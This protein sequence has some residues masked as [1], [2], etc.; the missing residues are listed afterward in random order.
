MWRMLGRLLVGG[1]LL[2]FVA[3]PIAGAVM[4]VDSAPLVA[5]QRKPTPEDA[6]AVTAMVRRL[7]QVTQAPGGAGT[8]SVSLA[9]INA[10]LALGERLIP[11][12]RSEAVARVGAIEAR[13]S[14]P[15]GPFGW[16]N[17]EAVLA[18]YEV[19][20]R[21]ARLR[22]G[23]LPLPPRVTL[24]VARTVGDIVLG[25][26]TATMAMQAVSQ[27]AISPEEVSFRLEMD[28]AQ[29]QGLAFRLAGLLRGA[30]M[31]T[32]PEIDTYYTAL[33]TAID[34]G[35]LPDRGS[36]LP[37]VIWTVKRA[38]ERAAPGR[39][40]HELTAALFALTRVCGAQ[41]FRMVVG[42]LAG[43]PMQK[44]TRSWS[45]NCWQVRLAG[46]PDTRRHFITA[47]A[48][49]AASTMKVSFTIGE[50]KELYDVGW[51]GGRFDFTD[52]AANAS[53]IRFADRF[54]TAPLD[55]WPQL[56]ARVQAEDDILIG[57]EGIPGELPRAE[58][59]ARFVAVDSPAYR[60]MLAEIDRRIDA[61]AVHAP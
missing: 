53:G 36:F 24:G 33:R 55:S 42:R 19:S 2:L 1:L 5:Q 26:E 12:L 15:L 49:K 38:Q 30:D 4:A 23:D 21:I 51:S 32:G 41:E 56:L 54:L 18:D 43:S 39:G 29:R 14:V 3:F 60:A 48:L 13:L 52:I 47:A 61:L 37:H 20:P 44:D 8:V 31:P 57:F 6:R 7:R 10:A 9:E 40:P 45:R 34:V 25:N 28:P 58:F 46:R 11:G 27:V 17:A 59:T 35:E 16:L 50:F 22:V